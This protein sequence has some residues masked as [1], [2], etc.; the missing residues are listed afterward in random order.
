MPAVE[1]ISDDQIKRVIVYI[2]AQQQALGFEQSNASAMRGIVAADETAT[3]HC[4]R[5]RSARA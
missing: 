3:L 2:R 4:R 5:S 1:D